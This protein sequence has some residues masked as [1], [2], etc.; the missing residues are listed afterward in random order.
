MKLKTAVIIIAILTLI[1]TML[2]SLL[3]LNSNKNNNTDV[4]EATN[5][6]LKSSIMIE[7]DICAGSGVIIDNNDEITIIT[8]EHVVEEAKVLMITFYNGESKIVKDFESKVD[9]DIAK[10]KFSSE[11]ITNNTIDS[12]VP[13][14]INT[15]KPKIGEEVFVIGN[16]FNY[17]FTTTKGIIS[18]N[19]ITNINEKEY[20]LIQTDAAT[21]NG[22]SGGGLFN[23]NGELIGIITLKT[24]IDGAEGMSFAIRI[25]DT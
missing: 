18:G 16:A 20:N 12:I 3:I 2:C 10:I 14:K 9:G 4:V 19:K 24:S 8:N 22:S 13:A 11:G 7:S 21:N 15:T 25:S 1:N 6:A 23:K 17:G 5:Q